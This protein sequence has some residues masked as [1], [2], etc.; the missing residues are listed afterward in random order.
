[1]NILNYIVLVINT[2]LVKKYSTEHR[3]KI[4]EGNK[5]KKM[6]EESRRKLSISSTGKKMSEEACIKMSFAKKGKYN[7]KKSKPVLQFTIDGEFIMEF[8]S[9]SEVKRQLGFKSATTMVSRCC[10]GNCKTAYGY[11]WKYK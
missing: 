10:S 7:T 4:S 11:I 9:I 2:V 5:G 6:S 8:P 3:R 1:M